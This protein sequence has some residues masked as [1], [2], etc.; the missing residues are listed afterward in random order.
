MREL[1][2]DEQQEL[3]TK[4]IQF[5]NWFAEHEAQFFKAVKESDY[6]ERDFFDLM[7][8][9]LQQINK[10]ILCLTGMYD[11]NISELI[12]TVDG[13]IKNI[14][15][16]EELVAAAP[17]LKHWI[18]TALK[19]E[20]DTDDINIEFSG[21]HLD[22]KNIMFYA[23]EHPKYPDEIDLVV[24]YEELIESQRDE[25]F[26]GTFII[27]DHILGE[28][29]SLTLIDNL[30]ISNEKPKD[31]D[32]I[33][34]NKLKGYLKWREKEFVERYL[35]NVNTAIE[36]TYTSFEVR[37]EDGPKLLAIMNTAALDWDG[38][39]AYPWILKTTFKYKGKDGFPV[40]ADYELMEQIEAAIMARLPKEKGYI[41]IGREI[42]NNIRDLFIASS[43]FRHC[44]KV[45]HAIVAQN[46]SQVSIEYNIFK[47]KYWQSFE[48]YRSF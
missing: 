14:V 26:N 33:P 13:I 36:D 22:E 11:D 15:F 29:K 4:Y 40:E 34:I 37:M 12:F 44:S 20:H 39:S 31:I 19:P 41:H 9:H 32:L 47:D 46:E 28:I 17:K 8:P 25:I 38:K 3:Q 7:L 18:F 6:I 5:W 27:L 21:L 48:R 43:E 30:S 35:A 16:V 2:I 24:V 1:Y 42:G 45:L 23:K 10:D